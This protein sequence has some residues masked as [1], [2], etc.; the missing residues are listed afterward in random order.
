M[1]LALQRL[2]RRARAARIRRPAGA[3]TFL[4]GLSPNALAR[5]GPWLGPITRAPR[6]RKTDGDGLL[7]VSRAVLSFPDVVHL[8]ADE[9][10]SL[11][12]RTL[13]LRAVASG[14]S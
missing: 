6:L 5:V 12:G 9:L 14:P 4:R 3:S 7:G 2:L 13:P 1:R 10:P 11:R 8:L